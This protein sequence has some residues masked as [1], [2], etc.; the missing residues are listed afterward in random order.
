MIYVWEEKDIV[1][2]I[3]VKLSLGTFAVLAHRGLDPETFH[4]KWDLVSIPSGY[5]HYHDMTKKFVTYILNTHK[6]VPA[7][8]SDIDGK[9]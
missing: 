2:G 6:A 3:I 1:P 4:L 7:K 9:I 5:I 8:W